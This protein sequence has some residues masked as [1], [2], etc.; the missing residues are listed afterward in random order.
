MDA[1]PID[2]RFRGQLLLPEQRQIYDYWLAL[3]D[4]RRMPARAD[5]QPSG[6]L[7]HLPTISLVERKGRSFR[8]RLAGTRLRDAYG[9][10]LTGK[11]LDEIEFDLPTQSYWQASFERA[12]LL[13]KPIQGVSAFRSRKRDAIFDF[14]MRLPLSSGGDAVDMLL[15]Y[16]AFLLPA[17]ASALSVKQTLAIAS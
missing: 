14:W 8:Y 5:V 2:L 6:L 12:V 4:G 9:L 11:Y 13:G 10:E 16:E 3:C 1:S 15:C 7:A 17:Q